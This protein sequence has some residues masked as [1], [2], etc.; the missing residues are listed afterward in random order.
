MS[1]DVGQLNVRLDLDTTGLTEALNEA[2]QNLSQVGRETS[3]QMQILQA[4][5]G[6][7]TA[8]LDDNASATERLG[9]KQ[10]FLSR[11]LAEQRNYLAALNTAYER[12]VAVRGADADATQ[13][14][15]VRLA[16]AREAEAQMEGELRRVNNQ[17]EEQANS[18]N[19]TGTSLEQI[20]P[21]LQGIGTSLMAFGAGLALALGG[22]AK[23]AMDF[24]AQMSKVAALSGAVGD[25]FDALRQKAL[26]LGSTTQFSA[27]QAAGGMQELAAAGM[28]SN[29]IVAAMPGVLAAAAASGEDMALVAET[30][31]SALNTFGLEASQAGHVADVLAAAANMS[32]LGVQDMAY[33]FKYAAPVAA[34]LG[35]SLEEVSAAM[36]EMGNAGIKGEQSGTTLRSAM[37]RLI[38]PPKEAAAALDSLGIS[39]TDSGGKM[40]PMGDIIGQFETKLSGMT[41]AQKAQTLAT[42][43][44]TEAVSGM[45]VLIEQGA[46]AFENYTSKLKNSGGAA[47]E[48][49]KIMQDNLKGSMDQLS[50]S[51]EGAAISIGSALA[52]AI[53]V[54]ADGISEVISRFNQLPESMK[55]T[56][57][58]ASAVAAGFALISGPILLLIGSLPT[59]TAGFTTLTGALGLSVGAATTAGA[60]AA[61]SGISFGALG[62]ALSALTGPVG[63]AVAALGLIAYKLSEDAVQVDLFGGKVSEATQKAVTAFLD[64][65]TQATTALNQLN[66]SG[67]AVSK[68]AADGIVKNFTGMKDQVVA[69]MQQQN[70]ESL[71][72]MRQFF[73]ESGALT[74]QNEA[75]ILAKI[76]ETGQA[77]ISATQNSEAAI[78]QILEAAASERRALTEQEKND[79]V[80]IQQAMV[81][82]GIRALSQGE[83]ESK[84][85]L[86]RMAQ[87]HEEITAQEAAAVVANSIKIKDE[88]IRAAE[89]TAN[90]T[91][92]EIIRQRDE[93]GAISADEAQKLIAAAI[94]VKDNTVKAAQDMHLKVVGEAQAQASEHINAVDWETGEIKSMFS[95]MFNAIKSGFDDNIRSFDAWLTTVMAKLG[96]ARPGFVVKGYETAEGFSEG[97]D[98]GA[99]LVSGSAAN[100]ANNAIGA[101]QNTL[102]IHSPSQ[103]MHRFGEGVAEGLAGGV[104]AGGGTVT[105][106]MQTVLQTIIQLCADVLAEIDGLKVQAAANPVVIPVYVDWPADIPEG[107]IVPGDYDGGG[108]GHSPDLSDND[109]DGWPD[110]V[111]PGG[112]VPGNGNLDANGDGQVGVDEAGGWDNW[113]DVVHGHATG[114]VYTKPTL[115][116]FEVAETAAARPEI[117]TPVQMMEDTFEAVLSKAGRFG[118]D[119]YYI[120]KVEIPARDIKEMRDVVDFFSRIKQTARGMGKVVVSVG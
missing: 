38:D 35:I 16:R 14:L 115:G 17:L 9:L 112:V 51:L 10:D 29:D 44:G 20:G 15:E 116:L 84:I 24:D 34:S 101:V 79:I 90:R 80:A 100:L 28:N 62:T 93:R 106:A 78:K 37:L 81:N 118:G 60:A 69:A 47:A 109:N 96:Y 68:E 33:G 66:W 67:Q 13:R 113:E 95:S 55:T 117:I 74:Q 61:T 111:P 103:V 21:K 54:V 36:V 49:A 30:M 72:S 104:E 5:F 64:L 65:N 22:T 91:I 53:R 18:A 94:T 108:G 8:R 114:G 120:E 4:E 7:A 1:S 32:A 40:R 98:A 82:E 86:E 76:Q 52:P 19:R 87:Q 58:V 12:S 110:G 48:T 59:I 75:E 23:I 50:S 27:S 45:M 6:A 70:Q 57:A 39:I 107:W 88:T 71:A 26:E 11:K 97:M 46:V 31:G 102:E 99:G 83:V 25:E 85:I 42:I 119:N 63:I 73:A 43:F 89:E 105:S 2:R 56:A 77:K 92:A 3:R 41:E